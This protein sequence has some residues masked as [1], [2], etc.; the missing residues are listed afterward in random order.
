MRKTKLSKH[1][2][3][4]KINKKPC[5]NTVYFGKFTKQCAIFAVFYL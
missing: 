4:V 2:D 1:Q 5:R 3:C